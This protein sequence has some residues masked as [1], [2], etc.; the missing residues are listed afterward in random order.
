MAKKNISAAASE[1]RI[2]RGARPS[3]FAFGD[4]TLRKGLLSTADHSGSDTTAGHP[5]SDDDAGHSLPVS[6]G[7][8]DAV[9][10]GYLEDVMTRSK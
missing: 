6:S 9:N 8:G 4:T 7:T 5:E 3:I 2:T 10:A 1:K